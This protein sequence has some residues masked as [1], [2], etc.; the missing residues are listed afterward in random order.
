MLQTYIIS[1]K[2]Y[3]QHSTSHIIIPPFNKSIIRQHL[4]KYRT[5]NI[6][7]SQS[8]VRPKHRLA[9]LGMNGRAYQSPFTVACAFSHRRVWQ[10][11]L[12]QST[13]TH[14]LILEEDASYNSSIILQHLIDNVT[15]LD[16]HWNFLHLG[17]CW[18]FCKN[19][20]IIYKASNFRII[21]SESPCCSHAYII[22]KKLRLSS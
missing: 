3:S 6:I 4:H 21:Q 17:R 8:F 18:D 5:S 19:E 15:D 13:H 11:F 20:E 7:V 16:Q 1:S 2:K 14:A 9:Y 10:H 12:S 22:K